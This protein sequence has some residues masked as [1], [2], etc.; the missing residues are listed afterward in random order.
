M[1]AESSEP[2]DPAAEDRPETPVLDR[3]DRSPGWPAGADVENDEHG[4]GWVWG[5]GVGRVTVRFETASTGPGPVRTFWT[6]DPAL[7]RVSPDLSPER[8]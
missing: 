7:R 5:S 8:T 6:D 2:A 4:R 1:P 3:F